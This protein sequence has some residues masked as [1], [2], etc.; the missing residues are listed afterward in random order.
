VNIMRR[1]AA[2]ESMLI[3]IRLPPPL[4]AP[5]GMPHG[6]YVFVSFL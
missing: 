6:L 4:R 3:A 2:V 1:L 5:A